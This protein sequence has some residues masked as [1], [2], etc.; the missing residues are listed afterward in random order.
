MEKNYFNNCSASYGNWCGDHYFSN[1]I[2]GLQ[3]RE[4]KLSYIIEQ[5]IPFQG[6]KET[7][8]I[9][10]VVIK[11]EGKKEVNNLSGK[12]RTV[13]AKIREKGIIKDGSLSLDERLTTD[14]YI[15]ESRVLNPGEVIQ[16]SLLT[17]AKKFEKSHV[18]VSLRGDGIMGHKIERAE[19][20]KRGG[21]GA[22]LLSALVAAYLGLIVGF[23]FLIRLGRGLFRFFPQSSKND[24]SKVIGSLFA[25]RGC[26]EEA[27]HYL[28]RK[29]DCEYWAESDLIAAKALQF[30]DQEKLV[31]YLKVLVDLLVCDNASYSSKAVILYNIARL[32]VHLGEK[33][34]TVEYI[35]TAKKMDKKMVL[36]RV[37]TDPIFEELYKNNLV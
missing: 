7:L 25:L 17:S 5:T 1:A 31:L 29:N 23:F 9:Q 8:A 18:E 36:W 13:N 21:L 30:R 2:Y 11:N 26:L 27:E 4:P 15:F 16:V 14:T 6:D 19:E 3:T 28:M 33:D 10:H 34:N 24:Q 32:Y 37:K 22:I 20:S 35:K 12:I